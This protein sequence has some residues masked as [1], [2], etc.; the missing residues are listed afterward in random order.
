[1]FQERLELASLLFFLEKK[2]SH[3]SEDNGS[4]FLRR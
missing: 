2:L 4:V 3:E 1:M